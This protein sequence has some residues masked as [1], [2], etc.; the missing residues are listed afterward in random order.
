MLASDPCSAPW[1]AFTQSTKHH[2]IDRMKQQLQIA[3]LDPIP[4]EESS[5]VLQPPVCLSAPSVLG[6]LSKAVGIVFELLFRSLDSKPFVL[7]IIPRC[8]RWSLAVK[9]R[10]VAES[11][12]LAAAWAYSVYSLKVLKETNWIH[13]GDHLTRRR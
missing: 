1:D 6:L 3:K 9:Q 12:R 4:A 7:E 11:E 2:V 5:H 13:G 8:P 10:G